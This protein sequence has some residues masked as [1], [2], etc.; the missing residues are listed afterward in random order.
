MSVESRN[1]QKPVCAEAYPAWNEP[2]QFL[3]MVR[4]EENERL[5][6]S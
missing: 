5:Y 4:S 6:P 3:F 2:C 1:R